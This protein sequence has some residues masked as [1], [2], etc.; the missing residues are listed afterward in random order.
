MFFKVTQYNHKD[1]CQQWPEWHENWDKYQTGVGAN[2]KQSSIRRP[3]E[4]MVPGMDSI[5]C[6]F[7]LSIISTLA[8]L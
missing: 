6:P 4:D 1:S 7:F 3:P 2:Y 8:I 5:F